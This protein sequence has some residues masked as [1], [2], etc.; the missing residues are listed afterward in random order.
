MKL[1]TLMISAA[2]GLL[3]LTNSSPAQVVEEWVA[4]YNGPGNDGDRAF[5]LDVDDAGNVYVTGSSVGIGTGSFDYATIKYDASG[6]QLWVA[7]YNGPG[8]GSDKA[9]SLALDEGGNVYVTGYSYGSGTGSDY[10]TIKYDALGNELWVARYNG[11]AGGDFANS[12][13]VDN[14]GNVYV[15]GNSAGI[16]TLDD[17]ATIKYDASGN[18]LWVTRFAGPVGTDIANSLAVDNDGNVYVTGYSFNYDYDYITIKY[19]ASGNQLWVARYNG[20][21]NNVDFAISLALDGVGNVCVTGWSYGNGTDID[22]ATIKYDAS[23]NQLWVARYNGP[24]NDD[25]FAI[26]LALDGVGNV[27]VTGRSV[28]SGTDYDYATIKYDA[29]GN[30]LWVATYNGPGNNADECQY[31]ALDGDG[32]VYVTGYS[33]GIETLD[34]YATIKYDA[35]GNELW[36]TRYNGPGNG[37]DI[38]YSL[39]LDDDGNVY[40]TG[41]STGTSGFFDYAT[42]KYSQPPVQVTM[43]PFNPPIQIPAGG[44]SFNFDIEIDNNSAVLYTIDVGLDVTLPGGSIYPI[45]LRRGIALVAG[46]SVIREDLTQFVPAGAPGGNYTYNGYVY[47][48]STWEILADDSFPFEKLAGDGLPTHNLGWALY[49]WDGESAPATSLPIEY[50]TISAYPNPFN[51]ST[52]ISFEIRDAGFV[53]LTCHIATDC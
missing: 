26:S 39:A 19:D 32:N 8:N 41:K 22:Y 48:H 17:Y 42:I 44:G 2:I 50:A 43:T 14:D 21:G 10:A 33:A 5:S 18:Q 40:V 30:Q 15:T 49:G 37:T 3:L 23:G 9:A 13:A 29:S 6:N 11:P 51:P 1:S 52:T 45:L 35:S 31:I 7:R 27:C 4:R 20:P 25:D 47:D 38:A 53:N 46:A 24:A 12:L 16:G 34:D 28:G 36:V